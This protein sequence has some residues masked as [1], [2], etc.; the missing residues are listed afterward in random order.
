MTD[1]A[2][3]VDIEAAYE[4]VLSD[5]VLADH[6]VNWTG[7]NLQVLLAAGPVIKI[8]RLGGDASRFTATPR[9]DIGVYASTVAVAAPLAD[10]IVQRLVGRAH[11]TS[12]GVIDRTDVEVLPHSVPYDDEAIRLVTATYRAATRRRSAA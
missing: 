11:A 8:S 3:Y 1:P 6:V 12:A 9:V 7:T 10:R 5:L 4:D 2:P